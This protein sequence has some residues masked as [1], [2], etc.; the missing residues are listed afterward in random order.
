M[1]SRSVA[2]RTADA[3]DTLDRWLQQQ[4]PDDAPTGGQPAGPLADPAQPSR[5]AGAEAGQAGRGGG[6][7]G[8]PAAEPSR[9]ASQRLLSPRHTDWLHHR[10]AVSGPA[11]AL[12]AFRAAAAGAGTLPWTLGI[13]SPPCSDERWAGWLNTADEAL[14][15]RVATLC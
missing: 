1:T 14:R 8:G 7:P 4:R 2:Q 5:D 13:C 12:T 10:L 15:E 9:T 3:T 6:E 11:D